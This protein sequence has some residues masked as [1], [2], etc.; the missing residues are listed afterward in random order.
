MESQAWRS[1]YQEGVVLPERIRTTM[2][3]RW[4]RKKPLRMTARNRMGR[5]LPAGR[6]MAWR[7][8]GGAAASAGG[9]SGFAVDMAV[10]P[11]RRG[12]ALILSVLRWSG[13]RILR[14]RNL[15]GAGG[16]SIMNVL[17][18]TRQR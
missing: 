12:T 13:P 11:G 4:P 14:V 15:D 9:P 10:S 1:W 16:P 7:G 2:V 3:R 6:P 5:T 8:G 18:E 17:R